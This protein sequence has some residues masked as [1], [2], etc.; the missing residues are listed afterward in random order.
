MGGKEEDIAHAKRNVICHED[1]G[2]GKKYLDGFRRWLK[3]EGN[4][5]EP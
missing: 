5:Y 2:S 3:S 4:I 1:G